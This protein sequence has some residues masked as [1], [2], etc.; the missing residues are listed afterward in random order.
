MNKKEQPFIFNFYDS[1][2]SLEPAKPFLKWAGGKTQLLPQMLA[3]L[4]Q[5]LLAGCI[6]RYVEPFVGGGAMFFYLAQACQVQK[7]ILCDA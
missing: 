4:P 6:E 2:N 7:F 3:F 5:E 1:T